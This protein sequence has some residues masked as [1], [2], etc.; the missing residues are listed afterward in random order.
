MNWKMKE[1]LLVSIEAI[2]KGC[3]AL[4]SEEK[5]RV[6]AEKGNWWAKVDDAEALEMF[7]STCHGNCFNKC[8]TRYRNSLMQM[9]VKK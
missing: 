2:R 5:D 7:P 6:K 8:K 9:Q 3:K 4:V 1:A